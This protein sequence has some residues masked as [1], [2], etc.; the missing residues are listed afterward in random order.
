LTIYKYQEKLNRHNKEFKNTEEEYIEAEML[1]D[2]T[3]MYETNQKQLE[4]VKERIGQRDSY[5]N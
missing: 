3:A 2:A 1:G 5:F 4:S